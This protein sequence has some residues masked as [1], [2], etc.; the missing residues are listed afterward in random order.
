[1]V[2]SYKNANEALEYVSC[3]FCVWEEVE[4]YLV[5][6]WTTHKLCKA[7][8]NYVKFVSVYYLVSDIGLQR[9]ENDCDVL[10]MC[11]IGLVDPE[12]I[13]ACILKTC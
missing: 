4:T 8:H 10:S 5:N 1:M 11:K 3:E 7:Y 6:V 2:N 12:K 9:L 13:S